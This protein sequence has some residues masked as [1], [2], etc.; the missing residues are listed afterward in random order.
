MI[1]ATADD[2][3]MRVG[4]LAHHAIAFEQPLNEAGHDLR[5]LL[6]EA[7]MHDE[8]VGDNQQ[9]AVRGQQMRLA[10][11]LIHDFRHLRL[12]RDGAGN[13]VAP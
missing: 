6:G 4:L 5:L 8:D 1:D 9:V 10:A 12:P 13:A 3:E 7:L 2:I 11:A